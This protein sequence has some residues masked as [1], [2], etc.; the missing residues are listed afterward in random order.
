[1]ANKPN[2]TDI[3]SAMTANETIEAA[4]VQKNPKKL[5]KEFWIEN[6]VC[7]LFADANVGKSIL[8]V[9]ISNAIAE[10]LGKD[11]TVLYYDFE[12]SKKQ[13][14]LRYTDEKNKNTF[15][16]ND[17]FIRVELDA[18][19]VKDYCESTKANFDEVIIS[20]IEANINKYNS[21]VIIV[22]NLS[23]LVNMKDTAT[24]A[25]L[26]MKN[27]CTIKKKYGISILVLSHTPKRNLGSPLTQNS[28]SGSKKLTNFFDAMFAVV[29]SLK[30]P[31][32]RYIKQIKVRTGEFK[33]GADHVEI[34]KIDKRGSF[35]GFE[36]V[37]YSTE[38]EQ[39]TKDRVKSSITKGSGK[40][41][42][43]KRINK[44]MFRSQLASAQIDLV[45]QMANEAFE[46]FNKS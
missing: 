29:M 8:A 28:L 32:L 33:Y 15:K 19:K 11:E 44:R 25:G 23:W 31:S 14:E 36:H 21:K 27:L 13:F 17:K 3:F 39:L 26:L 45:T 43:G 37:G 46:T 6:E 4:K 42:K 24:T 20:A 9:Q 22:D 7:C 16:F 10:K 18:D 12:L 1:M 2:L 34:C 41:L 5:W 38:D 30:D 35:L 40:K